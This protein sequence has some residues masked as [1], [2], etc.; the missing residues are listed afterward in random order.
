MLAIK[1][2]RIDLATNRDVYLD[3]ETFALNAATLDAQG[4]PTGRELRVSVLKRVNQGGRVTEREVSK[5]VLTTDKETGKGTIP[6][7]VEDKEGGSFVVRLA[8][9]DPFGNPIVADHPLEI[10]GKDDETRLRLLAD[11]MSFKVGETASVNLH[12]RSKPGTALLTWEADRILQYR[13]VSIKEGNNPLTWPVDGPQFPNFTLTASRMSGVAFDEARLDISVERDLRVAI[14]PLKPTVEP[15]GE[16]EVEVTTFDQ[17]GKPV[18][19]ELSLALVDQSLLRLFEDKLP[20]IGSYFYDQTRTG[21][22]STSATNTFTDQAQTTLPVS[23]AVVEEA[24][25]VAAQVRNDASRGEARDKAKEAF[26]MAVNSCPA[27]RLS[28]TGEPSRWTGS[29]PGE[30]AATPTA[31]ARSP[32]L[33]A[34]QPVEPMGIPIGG[35]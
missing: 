27:V 19:A 31:H 17:L 22:F 30:P 10:S 2:F 21:A 18:A 13:L 9:T 20:A 29:S 11:R 34:D 3:G 4:K 35:G 25:R 33:A 7:K 32:R 23:E 14:K 15:G 6:L 28:Q 8:G 12:S 26:N 1:G 5:H 16:V 24:E